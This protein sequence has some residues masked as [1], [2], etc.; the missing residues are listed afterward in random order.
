MASKEP[1]EGDTHHTQRLLLQRHLRIEFE[2]SRRYP[3]RLLVS[4]LH[5]QA[6]RPGRPAVLPVRKGGRILHKRS[7]CRCMK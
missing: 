4:G 6:F 3:C 2:E 1:L 7:E 5:R